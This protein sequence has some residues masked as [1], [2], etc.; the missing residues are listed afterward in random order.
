MIITSFDF[1]AVDLRKELDKPH[2]IACGVG[3]L[4]FANGDR[5]QPAKP[6]GQKIVER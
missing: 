3:G 5:A 6:R 2:E 4:R 1:A